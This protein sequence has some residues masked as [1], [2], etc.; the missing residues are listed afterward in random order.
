MRRGRARSDR[1]LRERGFTL[2]ELIVVITIIGLLAAAAVLAMPEGNGGLSAEAERFAARAKA[3]QE[4]AVINSRAT[5]LAVDPSG[6]AIAQSDGGA[7]R[8]LARHGWEA[9]TQPDFGGPSQARTR[10]DA[11][12]MADPLEVNLRRG[13]AR[14]QIVIGSDG[15]IQVRR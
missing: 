5:S 14:T 7:W 10:F 8:E 6:Y 13:S 15:E 11:T 9:G 1:K 4:A 2:V 12:G 3:A